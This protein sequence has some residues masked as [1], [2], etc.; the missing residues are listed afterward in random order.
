[1]I[2]VKNNVYTISTKSTSYV[3]AIRAGKYIENL[4][5][6]RKIGTDEFGITQEDTVTALKEK[7]NNC[8]GNTIEATAD[9]KNITL[10]SLKMEFSNPATGDY[11]M[12]PLLIRRA[13]GS[14]VDRLYYVDT[15]CYDG[16]YE[17]S[18]A[19]RMPYAGRH[20]VRW[21]NT[22]GVKQEWIS[23]VTKRPM[24]L[25]VI[26]GDDDIVVKLI[27]TAFEE[28]DV[29]TRRMVVINN[30]KDSI[31]IQQAAGMMLDL[32]RTDYSMITFDGLWT[33]E[34]HK[35]EKFLV[36]GTYSIESTMGTSGN[37][38]N[39]FFM[40]KSNE[41]S[42]H[43]GDVYSFN[44]IYSGNHKEAVEVSEYGKIRV[45]T[46]MSPYNMEYKLTSGQTFY[47]PEAVM[48]F[49]HEG[50]NKASYNNHQFVLEHIVPRQWAHKN[51]PV[52]INNWEATYFDFN[53]HKLVKLA[54]EASALGIELFVLDDGWFGKR[55]DDT[56]SLGDWFVNERKLGGSLKSLIKNINNE[57]LQFGIWVEPEM[58][59]VK[60]KLYEKHPDWALKSKSGD[61]YYGRNQL[62]LDY[63]NPAVREYIVNTLSELLDENNIAYVKW[64]MNRPITDTWAGYGTESGEFFHEYV[65]GLYDVLHRLCDTHPN[66]LFEGCSA[67]G[68]R[69]DLGILSYMPQIWTSDDSDA[70]ERMYIQGG[71]SYG[72][73]QST[74]G[75]HVSAA[76]NHQTQ[77]LSGIDT[78]FDVASMGVLGY[79]LDLTRLTKVEKE[80]IRHQVS[81]YK[82]Y[83]ELLQFGHFSRVRED[84]QVTTW[85]ITAEDKLAAVSLMYRFDAEPSLSYERLYAV[86]LDENRRYRVRN[87]ASKVSIKTFGNLI[88]MVSPVKIK[89]EG[90][91]QAIIDN[92]YAM[93]GETEE[94]IVHGS[95]LM[96]AG[97]S[98]NQRFVGTGLGDGTRVMPDNSARL[99]IIEAI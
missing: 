29:I 32:D 4:Y 56:S 44:L 73:P 24:T 81:I 50:L 58:I 84:R 69:F 33:R 41:A 11:R 82:Q 83:R 18:E 37:I 89:E 99:Y 40:L 35:N 64:D 30:G 93:N 12:L 54:K 95:T 98:L 91:L 72:Y 17:E 96:Y 87:V 27:Y 43:F 6:G 7:Y 92:M 22:P 80:A 23:D 57:G 77:R 47:T 28:C 45:M 34:R 49:S 8:Y 2:A 13:D 36:S 55:D 53:K 66:V 46:G 38:H 85:Q 39:P 16:V 26:L 74:M 97:I 3:C 70:R 14:L 71:T 75:A 20:E 65:C 62:V 31:V 79:E 59:S 9:E 51:R 78:R 90:V 63:T 86:G 88:N 21:S 76:P 25:E 42:E 60:S 19:T 52:L 5:Y 67:G 1:M 61:T 68:N 48:S 10:N 94:Y 15:V